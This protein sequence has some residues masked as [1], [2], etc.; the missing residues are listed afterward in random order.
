MKVIK[1]LIAVLVA[2]AALI[3]LAWAAGLA[4][5]QDHRATSTIVLP[6]PRDAVWNAITDVALFTEW[7][8][9]VAKVTIRSSAPGEIAWTETGDHG[10]IPFRTVAWDEPARIVTAIDTDQLPF[11]GRWVY[12]LEEVEGG[13]RITITEEGS[14]YSPFFRVIS[15]LFMS[16]HGTLDRYLTDLGA[17]F[18]QDV[19]P[20]HVP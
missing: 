3:G 5:P 18:S 8:S 6:A 12:L 10:A 14:V 15:T 7:R 4:L 11:G 20:E 2:I 19:R 17:R 9:D 1:Y 16:E 13:T